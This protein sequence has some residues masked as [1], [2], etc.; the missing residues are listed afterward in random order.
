[1]YLPRLSPG[2]PVPRRAHDRTIVVRLGQEEKTQ[3]ITVAVAYRLEVDEFTVAFDDLPALGVKVDQG[4]FRTAKDIYDAFTNSYAPILA[5]NLLVSLDGQALK[6]V[7]MQRSHTR[8]DENGAPLNHLRCDFVFQAKVHLPGLIRSWPRAGLP[9]PFI[10]GDLALADVHMLRFREANYEL[11]EGQIRAALV[12]DK[13]ILVL[14]KAVPE[15]AL[16]ARPVAELKPG[17]DARLRTLQATFLLDS[18]GTTEIRMP[19]AVSAATGGPSIDTPA[20]KETEPIA[21]TRSWWRW[22]Q[23]LNLRDLFQ[24]MEYGFWTLIILSLAVGGIHALT[25]G[26]GKTLVAAYLVGER[27][28]V[29]HAL[30]L[31]LVTTLTHTGVVIA[32]AAA[33]LF[34]VPSGRL[35]AA[36]QQNLQTVLEFGGGLLVVCL[37]FWLLLRR[38]AGQA[39]HFHLPGHGHH[40][41]GPDHHH[42]HSH[43]HGPAGHFHDEHGHAHPLPD[44]ASVGWWGLVVLGINGGIV[45]CWDAIVVLLFAVSTNRLWLALPMLLAFS[46]GL[47]AVLIGIGIAVVRAKSL[48]GPRLRSG[49][50]ARF[51]PIASALVVTVL[52]GWLCYDSLHVKPAPPVNVLPER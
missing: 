21:Q 49:R 43:D 23:E 36:G 16:Q 35:S 4:K 9:A 5:S 52:G 20:P 12:C 46:A 28:T 30:V 7:C 10:I 17:D 44:N 32:V 13:P 51:L 25:P 37:G 6:L 29:G 15:P 48:A 1:L 47:A 19:Q 40:H 34:F 2:H 14:T 26:H 39:D 24:E 3:Q 33:L 8:S 18:K 50:V 27:G 11:E 38:L 22:L 31:G 45:P 42:D 41:H